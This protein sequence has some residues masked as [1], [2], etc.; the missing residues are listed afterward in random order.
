MKVSTNKQLVSFQKLLR[1][2]VEALPGNCLK[3]VSLSEMSLLATQNCA[4]STAA[5]ANLSYGKDLAPALLF[6]RFIT[7]MLFIHPD[8][9]LACCS[10]AVR[11]APHVLVTAASPPT[12][13]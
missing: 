5:S 3:G 7:K 1:L 8:C 2:S 6:Q 13:V 11:E 10:F 4:A 12:T 9:I